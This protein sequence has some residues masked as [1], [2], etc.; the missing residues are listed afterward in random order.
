MQVMIML[1]V[2][3][4]KPS[5]RN[6]PMM[7]RLVAPKARMMPDSSVR[8]LVCIQKVPMTPKQRLIRKNRAV[9]TERLKSYESMG[10]AN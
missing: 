6:I 2:V 7:R 1:S 5:A 4:T 9:A 10:E 8:R 3:S